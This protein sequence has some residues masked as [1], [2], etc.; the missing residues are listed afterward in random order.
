MGPRGGKKNIMHIIISILS[1]IC[2]FGILII[3]HEL[4]HLLASKTIKVKVEKFSIGLG[5]KLLAKKIGETLYQLALIPIGGF[6]KVKGFEDVDEEK[7]PQQDKTRLDSRSKKEQ[8]FVLISG[9]LMNIILGFLLFFFLFNLGEQIPSYFYDTRIGKVEKDSLAY[10]AG[11]KPNDKIISI[12]NKKVSS[13]EEIIKYIIKPDKKIQ[14]KLL[15]N[16]QEITKEIIFYQ[17]KQELGILP[18]ISSEIGAVQKNS[19]AEKIG[20]KPKDIILQINKQKITNWYKMAE[21]I[22]ANPSSFLTFMIKR[23]EKILNVTITPQKKLQG[24]KIIGVIGINPKFIIKRYPFLETFKRSFSTTLM[25][26]KLTY[27]SIWKLITR[28]VSIKEVSGPIGIGYYIITIDPANFLK[29]LALISIN[30][31]VLNLLPFPILDG[32]YL[33]FLAIETALRKPINKKT[34]QMIQQVA[35]VILILFAF[36][37]SYNDLTKIFKK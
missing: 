17:K 32:G 7:N 27:V 29:L 21:I 13:W 36:F 25:W 24:N 14:I 18:F 3:F 30:L 5:P 28:E 37:V 6:V 22:Q 31:G 34:K 26:I 11:L 10:K 4:G 1:V 9:S 8:A 2:G 35:I 16:N 19:P 23:Q 33:I 20:L 15:R 12:G